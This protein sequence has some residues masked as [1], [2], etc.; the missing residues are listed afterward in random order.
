MQ[1]QSVGID[2][3]KTTHHLVA[4]GDNGKVL[5]KK[6]CRRH[7]TRTNA[8]GID[9]LLVSAKSDYRDVESMGLR[10]LTTNYEFLP[11]VDTVLCP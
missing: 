9:Q 5:L 1:I 8:S 6:N 4:L 3:G 7:K 10:R 11:Q 2:L